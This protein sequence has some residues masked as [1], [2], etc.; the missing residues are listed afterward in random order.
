MH[1]MHSGATVLSADH[2]IEHPSRKCTMSPY[3]WQTR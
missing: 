2:I 1:S 3:A